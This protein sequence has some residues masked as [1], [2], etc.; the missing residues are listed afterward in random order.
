MA[1]ILRNMGNHLQ[2]SERLDE[3]TGIVALVCAQ[4]DF[5]RLVS[6]LAGIGD[7]RFGSLPLGIAIRRRDDGT[8]DESMAVVAQGVSH[9]A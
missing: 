4:R 1:V 2:F 7:H 6:H 9:V 8:C 5:S 3:F